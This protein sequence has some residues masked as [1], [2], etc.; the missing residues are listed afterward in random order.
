MVNAKGLAGLS[1]HVDAELINSEF[2][3][4]SRI[5]Y[6]MGDSTYRHDGFSIGQDY[7]R[8]EGRTV[9]RGECLPG[10]LFVGDMVGKGAFSEVYKAVWK[11]KIDERESVV[12]VKEVCLLAAS[13]QRRD[14]L[15]KELRAL[16]RIKCECLV[17]LEGAFLFEDKVTMVLEFM[18]RGSLEDI[19][20]QR[21]RA[22]M[23]LDDTFTASVAFQM[24]WGLAYLHSECIIHR[25]VKPGNVLVDTLGT[26]KLCDFGLASISSDLSLQT[27]MVGTTVYMAPE[28]LRAQPYGR[29]S[30]MWSFGLVLLEVGMIDSKPFYGQSRN[31]ILMSLHD[32][33]VG[34]IA[35]EYHW[36]NSLERS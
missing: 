10:S 5:G 2:E 30:D 3:Q 11:H 16:C 20:R 18:D 36:R 17:Q 24:L 9:T 29:S 33:L 8:L 7:L 21:N 12:A 6:E 1:L 22:G 27:T 28:R 4:S 13:P 31:L 15:M 14:M 35:K 25:D 19:I 23:R 34:I 26:V 32:R